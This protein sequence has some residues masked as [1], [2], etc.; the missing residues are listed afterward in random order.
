MR[1]SLKV[2]VI[3]KDNPAAA[4]TTGP[5]LEVEATTEDA[6]L[7]AARMLLGTR[8]ERIRAICFGSDCILAYVERPE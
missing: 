2:F 4:P 7:E 6:L 8:G 3:S 1:S 5:E